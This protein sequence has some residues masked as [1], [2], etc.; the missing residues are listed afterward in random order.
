MRVRRI[1]IRWDS[2]IQPCLEIEVDDVDILIE[3]IN[4]LLTKNN[5]QVCIY[6]SD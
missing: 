5:W 1:C 4:I 3:F 2:Y 6:C